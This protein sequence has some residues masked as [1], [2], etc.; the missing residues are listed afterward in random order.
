MSPEL[1]F[2]LSLA[3]RMA[4]SAAFVVIAS[5]ITERSGPAIGALVATLPVS[6]GPSYLFLALDHDAAFIGESALASLP[7]NAATILMC[8]VFVHLAQRRGLGVSLA[9]GL[10]VWFVCAALVR[11]VNWTLP[12]GILFNIVALGVCLPLVQRFRHAKMPLITRRWYDIPLRAA[13]VATLVAIVVTLSNIVGPRVSGVI[14]LFPAVF[15][16]LILILTPRIGG[17]ATAA[18]LANGQWGLIGFGIAIV[19]LHFAAQPLGRATALSLALATC[20]A[21]N[22]GLYFYGRR[23]RPSS[24]PLT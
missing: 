9:A 4:V 20:I 10:A 24:K 6:A 7:M 22:L 1:T 13:L 8:L 19:V 15:T 17:R 5:M 23:V 16:S 18:V 21:W 14:A 2:L 11:A 3:L 12:G